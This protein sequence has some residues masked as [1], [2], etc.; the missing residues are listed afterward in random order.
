MRLTTFSSLLNFAIE[1]EKIGYEKFSSFLKEPDESYYEI[2]SK[3]KL[4]AE[5]NIKTLQTILRENVTELVME[6]CDAIESEDFLIKEVNGTVL[7]QIKSILQK[8]IDFIKE[9]IKVINLKE[10]KRLL[11]KLANKKEELIKT[12]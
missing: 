7:L 9:C 3:L 5:K 8:Q 2:I 10:V 1:M 6:P 12:I 4:E 11:E